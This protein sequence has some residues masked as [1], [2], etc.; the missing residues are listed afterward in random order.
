M[1]STLKVTVRHRKH[2]L[3]R[4]RVAG[5]G[6]SSAGWHWQAILLSGA[7]G[8]ASAD[9]CEVGNPGEGD[10][11][12]ASRQSSPHSSWDARERLH[13]L[14]LSMAVAVA[15]NWWPSTR[16]FRLAPHRHWL[17]RWHPKPASYSTVPP[18]RRVMTLTVAYPTG[19]TCLQDR[20]TPSTRG[21]MVV[22]FSSA[23]SHHPP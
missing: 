21:S 9:V 16:H 10:C 20:C 3:K 6:A 5:V 7:T 22:A 13:M 18:C 14:S 12:A 19:P 1:V 8:S 15:G 11:R 23:T 2:S 17:N 4:G